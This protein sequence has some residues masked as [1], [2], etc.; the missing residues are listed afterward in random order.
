MTPPED[1]ARPSAAGRG[2]RAWGRAGAGERRSPAQQHRSALLVAVGLVA[3]GLA[4]CV[5]GE[6]RSRDQ[7]ILD[8]L[9]RGS[10]D[11]AMELAKRGYTEH[12]NDPEAVMRLAGIYEKAG[13]IL[14]AEQYYEVARNLGAANRRVGPPL[15]RLAA[16]NGRYQIAV[17]RARALLVEY[18]EQYETR[19]LLAQLDV[20]LED[21]AS[22]ERELRIL[23]GLQPRRPDAYLALGR[24]YKEH[25]KPEQARASLVRFLEL[26]K[27]KAEDRALAERLL[28]ELSRPPGEIR[29]ELARP[30]PPPAAAPPP[31]LPRPAEPPPQAPAAG[32]G[33]IRWLRSGEQPTNPP[34]TNAKPTNPQ[35]A[36]KP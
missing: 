26:E 19:L 27:K 3:V 30:T 34:P 16:K 15:I 9:K 35:K 29:L 24:L 18:P 22:A 2:S 8:A 12:P 11:Q 4:G 31:A 21:P 6:P 13:E 32:S 7:Q 28:R 33:E 23:L 5:P 14:R 17:D 25:G 1:L 20:L 36:E 10:T